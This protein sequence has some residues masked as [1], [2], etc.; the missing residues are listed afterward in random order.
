MNLL[1]LNSY[2]LKGAVKEIFGSGIML[3]KEFFTLHNVGEFR[4]V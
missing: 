2:F 1:A 3:A 4:D